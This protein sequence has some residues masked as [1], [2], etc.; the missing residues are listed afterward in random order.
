MGNA[1]HSNKSNSIHDSFHSHT[2]KKAGH[3]ITPSSTNSGSFH[4]RES[5][6]IHFKVDNL[7]ANWSNSTRPNL[8]GMLDSDLVTRLY[9][10]VYPGEGEDAGSDPHLLLG[11]IHFALA[12]KLLKSLPKT[13]NIPMSH[14]DHLLHYHPNLPNVVYQALE[15]I[16]PFH[17]GEFNFELIGHQ[18]L[19]LQE[20]MLSLQQI[21]QC[22]VEEVH[23]IGISCMDEFSKTNI[24]RYVFRCE[25]SAEIVSY[26]AM[27]E[28][29]K[30]L[31]L[32][33]QLGG[34]DVIVSY[35]GLDVSTK[36]AELEESIESW[37]KLMS[38]KLPNG[39]KAACLALMM[40]CKESWLFKPG[41]HLQSYFEWDLPEWLADSTVQDG[42]HYL[43]LE[44]VL[45]GRD[46][47]LDVE[48]DTHFNFFQAIDLLLPLLSHP[49]PATLFSRE[50][51]LVKTKFSDKGN[52]AQLIQL[53]GNSYITQTKPYP[54]TGN[55]MSIRADS[56]VQNC[57]MVKDKRLIGIGMALGL[58]E[59]IELK[60]VYNTNFTDSH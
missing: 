57:F 12:Q 45:N 28:L 16:G 32:G 52:S 33:F 31:Q 6:I 1:H 30:L 14:L 13:K 34:M 36:C 11:L 10:L 58:S 2:K 22:K 50:C 15:S 29:K 44:L 41:S 27:V 5:K 18:H 55:Y 9:C 26:R 47:R 46:V 59:Y 39:K 40:F 51:H 7:I 19:I 4:R 21:I 53:S 37:L 23:S 54:L 42:L 48:Q 60:Q 17:E 8:R 43:E 24:M 56:R 20:L 3:S 35:P 38:P 49:L 25:G